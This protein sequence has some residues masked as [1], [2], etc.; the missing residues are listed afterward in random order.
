MGY[1]GVMQSLA[2]LGRNDISLSSIQMDA[3]NLDI[4]GMAR[5]PQAIPN[6]VNQFKSE[7]NL[8]GRSF[9]KLRIARNEQNV[10]TFELR[11]KE[12]ETE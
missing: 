9:E 6:W 11:T 3:D 10:L 8:V 1:S 4:K 5:D 7:I 2:Q 12:E